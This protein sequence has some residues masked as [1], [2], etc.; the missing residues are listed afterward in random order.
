VCNEWSGPTSPAEVYYTGA[1]HLNMSFQRFSN[2][3][4]CLHDCVTTVEGPNLSLADMTVCDEMLYV[5]HKRLGP[6]IFPTD[7]TEKYKKQYKKFFNSFVRPIV[8]EILIT[9][10]IL[11]VFVRF[12]EI[13]ITFC[14]CFVV[15]L[16][17]SDN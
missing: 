11:L 6:I 12:R 7:K 10:L 8:L 17:G 1:I 15:D 3:I 16:C 5:I 14:L 13:V 2:L 4:V 9:S